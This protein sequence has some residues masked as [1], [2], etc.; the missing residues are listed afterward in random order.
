MM[1]QIAHWIFSPRPKGN[2]PLGSAKVG[3]V[4]SGKG[5]GGVQEEVH[6][7][8]KTGGRHPYRMDLEAVVCPPVVQV[9]T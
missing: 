1:V 9:M 4:G 5:E 7:E 8:E 2:K 6:V 3:Q